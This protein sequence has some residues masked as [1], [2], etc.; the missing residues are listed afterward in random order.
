MMKNTLLKILAPP[1]IFAG[2]FSPALA[3]DESALPPSLVEVVVEA[4][5]DC[6]ALDDGKLTIGWGAVR[7]PDLDGDELPDWSLDM[8]MVSCS[9]ARTLFCGTGGCAAHFVVG[10][11][12]AEF[13]TKEWRTIDLG[14]LRA[15][16]MKAHGVNCDGTNLTPCVR[17]LTWDAT[18]RKWRE[19]G[20]P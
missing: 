8:R 6:A 3:E 17:A 10:D 11:S 9:S 18:E 15:L 19:F 13:L 2:A 7:R 12:R 5:R 16:L 14:G 20:K 4:R 1:L